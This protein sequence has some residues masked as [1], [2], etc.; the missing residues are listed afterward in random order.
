MKKADLAVG[1]IV[2]VA[3]PYEGGK[4]TVQITDLDAGPNG[5]YATQT[6]RAC[7]V[8]GSSAPRGYHTRAKL[9]DDEWSPMALSPR[10][11]VRKVG[12]ESGAEG[13]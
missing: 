8:Q 5:P 11:V 10:E 9:V 1:D 3:L 7:R 12:P 2:F 4:G 6:I 13:D